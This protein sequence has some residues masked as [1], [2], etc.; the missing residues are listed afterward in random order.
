MA[1]QRCEYVLVNIFF[2]ALLDRKC[3]I[4]SVFN[5]KHQTPHNWIKQEHLVVNNR[6]IVKYNDFKSL[7]YSKPVFLT[8]R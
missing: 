3:V 5:I 8:M 6:F 1:L 2:Y 4:G 7:F